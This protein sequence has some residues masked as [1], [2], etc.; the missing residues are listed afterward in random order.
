MVENGY[1]DILMFFV[2][3]QTRVKVKGGVTNDYINANFVNVSFVF[4]LCRT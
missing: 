1:L 4:P 2:D 3:D